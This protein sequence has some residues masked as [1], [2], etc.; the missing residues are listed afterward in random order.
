LVIP[1]VEVVLD[2]AAIPSKA[3]ALVV[4]GLVAI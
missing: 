3:L 1:R 2:L 4:L